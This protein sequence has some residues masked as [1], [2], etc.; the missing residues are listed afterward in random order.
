[1]DGNAWYAKE[2]SA[3]YKAGI[4][5]GDSQ[6]MFDPNRSITREEM[7]IMLVRAYEH[8]TG[9]KMEKA[10]AEISDAF[11]ISD[12]ALSYVNSAIKAKLLT[13]RQEGFFVPAEHTTRAEAA[14]AVY[15]LLK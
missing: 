6:R 9:V 4:I 5:T 11:E 2:V 15:N 10:S 3:A 14:Q 1:M 8:R 13:G 7:A 12:W